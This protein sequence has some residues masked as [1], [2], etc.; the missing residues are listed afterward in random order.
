M[1]DKKKRQTVGVRLCSRMKSDSCANVD[2]FE[3]EEK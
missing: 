1:V 2:Y 3:S